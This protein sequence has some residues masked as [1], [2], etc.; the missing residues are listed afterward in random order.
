MASHV[1]LLYELLKM[2]DPSV[3]SAKG[4]PSK[5]RNEIKLALKA[6][7]KVTVDMSHLRSLSPSFA[8]EAFGP[9]V[10]EFGEDVQHRLQFVNDPLRLQ[11]RIIEAMKRRQ[12]VIHPNS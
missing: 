5:V 11:T 4:E 3:A 9:L 7:D 12:L 1:I 6:S 8:Y 10:D 2:E